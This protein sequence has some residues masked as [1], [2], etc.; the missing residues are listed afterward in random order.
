MG[1]GEGF[2]TRNFIDY[3]FTYMVRVIKS[4]KLRWLGHVARI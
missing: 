1:S 3:T 4:K 2:T